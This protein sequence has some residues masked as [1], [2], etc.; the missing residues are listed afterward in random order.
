MDPKRISGMLM[1]AAGV[2]FLV[3]G[4][5]LRLEQPVWIA[6]GAVLVVL[7]AVVLKRSRGP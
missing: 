6:L 1:T 7:G 5:L 3:A 2:L 4:L